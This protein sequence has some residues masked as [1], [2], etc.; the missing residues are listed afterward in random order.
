[1]LVLS[2]YTCFIV[3]EPDISNNIKLYFNN[4]ILWVYKPISYKIFSDVVNSGK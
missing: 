4:D 3:T 1:M 2:F